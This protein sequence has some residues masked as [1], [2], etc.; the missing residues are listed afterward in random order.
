MKPGADCKQPTPR[1]GIRDERAARTVLSRERRCERPF[2]FYYGAGILVSD[3]TC[4]DYSIA[5]N[6]LG[7][8]CRICCGVYGEKSSHPGVRPPGS[9]GLL[10]VSMLP[11]AQLQCMR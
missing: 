7:T 11:A 1:R 4:G 9:I 6:L 5:E 10:W 8:A 3:L 2:I